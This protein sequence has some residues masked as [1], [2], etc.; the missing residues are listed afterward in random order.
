M[1][2]VQ[3]VR[4]VA[5]AAVDMLTTCMRR[6]QAITELAY[7]ETHVEHLPE[8]Y[9]YQRLARA[10]LRGRP[11]WG[12]RARGANLASQYLSVSTGI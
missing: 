7:E 10:R 12:R 2:Q 6:A 4:G 1:E 8:S 3:R 5:P 9:R 11:Q